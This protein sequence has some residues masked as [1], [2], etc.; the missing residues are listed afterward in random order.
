MK[1][2]LSDS[3]V[4]TPPAGRATLYY[5]DT[6][7]VYKAKLSDG[8]VIVF[9]VTQEMV[10]DFVGN[11]IQDSATIDVTYNDAD[12]VL[13]LDVIQTALNISLIP[14]VPSGN[15]TSTNVQAALNELQSDIDTRAT[16]TDLNNHLNDTTDAHDASAISVVPSGNLSSTDVQAAL[17]ELQTDIDNGGTN[18]TNHIN[19]PTDAHDAS[20][21]SVVP[22][23]NLS[24]TDVQAA[25][26]ELQGDIDS[27]NLNAQEA[28]Q[29]AIGAAINAGTQDGISVVYDDANDKIDFTNT[30]KG[31]IAVTA[32]VALPDP[33]TQYLF[34][35]GT[36]P[37]SGN[38]NLG[39]NAIT[40]VT[41]VNGVTVEAHASRHLPNG[42][43][44]LATG[45]PSTIG[46]ANS[47]G[48][49]NAFARQDHVHDHGSQTDPTHHAVATPTANGF[50]SSTDKTK[51]DGISGQRIF[52][53]GNVA[54]SAFTG[55]PRTASV[56]FVTPMPN[57][58]YAITITGEDSRSWRY[59][60]KTVNGF[61]INS[62]ANGALTGE[63]SWIA[64][65]NG[66]TV[67]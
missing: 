65:S 60:N 16:I 43:D 20:A 47:T 58:N 33:H 17:V 39:A 18:L 31:S 49:A 54:A 67:E 56:T 5:N 10:E 50:M 8:T 38:L 29:D 46:T 15:L 41:T 26:V 64:I 9:A 11:L 45:I 3:E 59:Q 7:K 32:H 53:S 34:V 42:A 57:T 55:A 36:K 19:N 44:P 12:N 61:T 66:E 14:N 21:I 35:S 13:T 25:L 4:Q 48:I 62:G 37:M 63:V 40:N 22:S 28:A 30:D 23:G 27:I 1:G 24:S 6:D 52:K 51:L 2:V